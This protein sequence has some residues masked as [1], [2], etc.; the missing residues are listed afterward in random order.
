MEKAMFSLESFNFSKVMLDLEPSPK[1]ITIGQLEPRGIFNAKSREYLLT[2]LFTAKDSETEKEI[3]SLKCISVFK[4][5][6]DVNSVNDIPFFFFANSI[7]IMY[8]YIRAFVSTLSLQ[9]NYKPIIL[10]TMNL[11]SLKDILMKNTSE[12]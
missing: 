2:I 12:K 10:P 5:S 8:P 1:T 7:A 9:A 6:T 3:I 4:F 11:S